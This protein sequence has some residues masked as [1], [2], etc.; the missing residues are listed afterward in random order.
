MGRAW[1][2]RKRID[3]L[4][5]IV[6]NDPAPILD[7]FLARVHRKWMVLR[8]IERI[9]LCILIASVLAAI[10][11]GVLIWRGESAINM[12]VVCLG[13][14][15]VGGAVVGWMTRPSLFDAAVEVDR[16][17]HLADLLATAISIRRDQTVVADSLDQQWSSTILALAEAR[18]STIANEALILRR[19]G[20]RAWGG[21]GLCTAIVLTVGALSS[22]PL[23]L[24]ARNVGS[25]TDIATLP[26]AQTTTQSNRADQSATALPNEIEPTSSDHSRMDGNPDHASQTQSAPSDHT[27]SA[28]NDQTGSG[29]GRTN[30]TSA[31][32]PDLTGTSP[33]TSASTGDLASGGGQTSTNGSAG[34]GASTPAADSHANQPVPPWSSSDWPKAQQRASEQIRNG[35]VPDAYRDLVRD[36]FAR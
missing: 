18:C 22:N 36:Y 11:A 5:F 1:T 25:T 10:L 8:A 19:F 34:A 21:I 6:V 28:A 26:D 20:I 3:C 35:D 23:V 9:G 13:A 15:T 7:Y 12:V 27:S 2:T 16:Q 32:Q 33:T 31:Q 29:T 24:Q 17:L 4:L 30:D 14:G